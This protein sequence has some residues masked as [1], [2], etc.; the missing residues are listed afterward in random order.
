MTVSHNLGLGGVRE[1][2]LQLLSRLS[3]RVCG[4]GLSDVRRLCR[5]YVWL[6][7]RE[8]E[9]V[10]LKTAICRQQGGAIT[11]AVSLLAGTGREKSS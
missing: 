11:R 2:F 5:R 6:T 7:R 8:I 9:A 3:R 4:V 10:F 1:H